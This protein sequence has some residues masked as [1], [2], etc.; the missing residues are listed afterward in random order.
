MAAAFSAQRKLNL[1]AGRMKVLPACLSMLVLQVAP[2]AAMAAPGQYYVQGQAASNNQYQAAGLVNDALALLHANRNE[3]AVELLSR[4]VSL[5]PDMPEAHHN[6][7]LALAKLGKSD[8]AIAH[9]EKVVIIAPNLSSSLLTLGGLYQSI[10]R[11]D[12]AV[13]TYKEFLR[14]FPQDSEAPKIANLARGLENVS[15]DMGAGATA[16]TASSTSSADYLSEMTKQGVLSWPESRMPIRVFIHPVQAMPTF[17]PSFQAILKGAFED[18][19]EAS[20]GRVRFRYTTSAADSDIECFWL[21]NP[22]DLSNSAE[23]GEARVFN[24]REGIVRGTVKLLTVPL[25]AELPLT[26]NRM[27]QIAL[28]E[29]GHVLGLTGHTTNP[30]DAMFFSSSVDDAWKVLSVRDR[31]TITKLYSTNFAGR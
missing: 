8:E 7:A 9:L 11:I 22:A 21:N 5:A 6:L 26:D 16:L 14:R 1:M 17:R 3:E 25:S 24:N 30:A 29:V 4:A 23:S 12:R 18:W 31:N 15:R 28:H 10:G 2:L 13:A 27:R 19:S 20:G